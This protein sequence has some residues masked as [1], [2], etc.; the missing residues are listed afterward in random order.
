MEC[1]SEGLLCT[2]PYKTEILCC[3][4]SAI[5]YNSLN[6]QLCQG[7]RPPFLLLEARSRSS[8]APRVAGAPRSHAS[9]CVCWVPGQAWGPLRGQV[10]AAPQDGSGFPGVGDGET[11]SPL[12]VVLWPWPSPDP[13]APASLARARHLHSNGPPR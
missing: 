13:S 7:H 2:G 9:S 8:R 6:A 10:L 12:T 5:P 3:F 4:P 11:S 1:A